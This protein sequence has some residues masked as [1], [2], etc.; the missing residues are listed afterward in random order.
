MICLGYLVVMNIL[1]TVPVDIGDGIQH[2]SIAEISWKHPI[3]LLDHWGKPLFTLLSSPFA[4]FGFKAY[5]S[6]NILVFFAT[7]LIAFRLFK[8][9]ACGLSYYFLFPVLLLCV[10]DYT[11][12]ILGGMTEPLFGLILVALIYCGWRNHWVLFA[13]IAS[14]APFVRSEG[15]LV[16]ILGIV[17]LLLNKQWRWLPLIFTGFVIYGVI[18]GFVFDSFWWFFEQD[19]YPKTSIYG[20]GNWYHY[21]INLDDHTGVL[22]LL[23]F[24]LSAIGWIIYQRNNPGSKT[25]YTAIFGISIYIGIVAIHSYLWAYGLKGSLG[26]TRIATLGLPAVLLILL[27]GASFWTRK[28]SFRWRAVLLGLICAG[29][30]KEFAEL[31]Y[32]VKQNPLQSILIQAT[33]YCKTNFKEEKIYYMSPLVAWR[34][35]ENV[36]DPD[37]RFKQFYFHAD[38]ANIAALEEG[39]IVIR[40]PVFGPVEQGLPL[41]FVQ[42]NPGLVEIKTFSSEEVYPLFTKEP[43]KIRIFKVVK[44]H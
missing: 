14:F 9:A 33:D 10:P 1:N 18:G 36:K 29:I 28:L 11:Y 16:I 32:P 30:G 39:S 25:F 40:D 8:H 27:I 5:I 15:M 35:G 44:K 13:V 43:L 41:D 24:P 26:L 31:K 38:Q 12:C 4:Q 3:F 17:L 34:A 37:S 2:F 21:L 6:F 20:S 7:C 19:P 42:N 23:V 22:T